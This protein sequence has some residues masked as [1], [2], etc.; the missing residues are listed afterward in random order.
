MLLTIA[1]T[2]EPATDLGYLLA[3]HPQ[4]CQRFDLSFGAAHVWYPQADAARCEAALWVDVDPVDL[5]R[6][7]GDAEG[8]LSQYV[9]DRPY[10][11]SSFLSVAIAR[12]YAS[13]LGGD[14]KGR[15]ELAAQALPLIAEVPVLRSRGGPDWVR[16]CFE[17]LGYQVDLA[18][19][20]LDAG[21]PEWGDSAYVRLRLAATLRLQTLLQHL[22]VLLA[23][24]D[25]DRHHYVGDDEVDKLVAKAGEWL[26]GHPERDWI[27]SRYL[28]RRRSLVRAA[29]AKLTETDESE[30]D[31][32]EAAREAPDR[33]SRS[34]SA[35]TSSAWPRSPTRCA[36]AGRRAWSTSAAARAACSRACSTS[37]AMRACSASMSR[38]SRSSAPPNASGSNACRRCCAHAST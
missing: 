1:T 38:C 18:A 32:A 23:A 28:K 20:P 13:A 5:V 15:P 16:R 25:G 22:Y 17:P 3:K 10:A 26:P 34:R 33:P 4:R 21:F 2:F 31:E 36:R 11:A 37:A 7:K 19:L 14:C 29:L 12:V 9:N 35:S 27:V 30:L 8:A 24:I 6:G